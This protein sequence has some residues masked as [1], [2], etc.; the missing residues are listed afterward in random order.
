MRKLIAIGLI[1]F[2]STIIWAADSDLFPLQ[3]LKLDMTSTDLLK[4]YPNVKMAY[5]LKDSAGQLTDGLVLCEITNSLYWDGALIEIRESKIQSW[6]YARTKDYDRAAKNI[7]AIHKA[8]TQALGDT[9]EKKVTFHLVKRGKVRSP[10]FVWK[11]GDALAVFTHSPG[12]EHKAG[13]PFI[14]QLT[15]SPDA[16]ALQSLFDVAPDAKDKDSELFQEVTSDNAE[17]DK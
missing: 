7:G 13:E 14:C 5:A 1:V 3:D 6:G 10:M 2:G 15:I 8:L 16:K 9:L 12:K 17:A 11:F 4:A